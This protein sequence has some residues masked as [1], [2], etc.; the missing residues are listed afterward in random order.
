MLD[1]QAGVFLD[2]LLQQVPHPLLV[3][4]ALRLDRQAVH[5]HRKVE[6]LQVQVVVLGGV[7]QHGVEMQLVD[8]GDGAQVAR[9]R[10]RHLDMRLA[11]QHEQV[12]DLERTASV[13]DV[14][15]AALRQRALVHAQDAHLAG[16]D[17]LRDLE[18]MRDDMQ[19]RVGPGLERL[20]LVAF[21]LQ[22][23]RRVAFGGV[24]QQPDDDVEQLGDAG[25]VPRRDEAD[26]D[27]V[28][29]AQRLLERRMQLARVDVAL[30]QVALDELRIDLDHLFDQRPV[31]LGHRREIDLGRLGAVARVEEAVDDARAACRRQVERQAF[32]AEGGLDAADQRGQVGARHVDLVDDDEA[33]ALAF[34]GVG[35]HARRHRLDAGAVLGRRRRVRHCRRR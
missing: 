12:A 5:R 1:A 15:L 10:A 9:Q 4:A 13:A 22:E 7:V 20:R 2:D 21:A 16:V 28:A 26:R 14:E 18:G 17:V 33:A 29:F 34:G 35:H 27:Q 3:A 8:L 11:L 23:G 30:V 24:R 19:R 6:R 32:A 25:A 31:R